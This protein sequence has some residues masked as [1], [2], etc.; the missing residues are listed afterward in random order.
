MSTRLKENDTLKKFTQLYDAM[1]ALQEK[2]WHIIH[3]DKMQEALCGD[4]P[5]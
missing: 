4:D 3:P 2:L 5:A 1:D